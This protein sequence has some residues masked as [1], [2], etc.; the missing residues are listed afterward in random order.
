MK[1][2]SDICVLVLRKIENK[3]MFYKIQYTCSNKNFCYDYGSNKKKLYVKTKYTY[4]KSR[5]FT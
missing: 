2:I 4:F 1:N 3:I 5:V